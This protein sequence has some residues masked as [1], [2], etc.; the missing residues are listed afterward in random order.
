MDVRSLKRAALIFIV[1]CALMSLVVV[2]DQSELRW[3][4]GIFAVSFWLLPFVGYIVA[5]Y[6]VPMF[7]R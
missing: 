6:R 5:L 4:A 3:L 7:S 2:F 1:Q